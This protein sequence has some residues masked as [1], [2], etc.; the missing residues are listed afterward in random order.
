MP[1][2]QFD[3]DVAVIGA[4]AAGLSA[5]TALHS[6]HL[7]FVV[8]EASHRIGG[9]AYTEMLEPGVPFDLGAHWIHSADINPFLSLANDLGVRCIEEVEEFPWARVFEDGDWLPKSAADDLYDFYELQLAKVAEFAATGEDKSIY[10]VMDRDDRWTPYFDLFFAQDFVHDADQVSAADAAAFHWLGND[11]AVADGFGMLLAR[12]GADVPVSLNSAV[13]EVDWSGS[14]VRLATAKG[15]VSARKVIITVSTGVL[16]TNQILFKPKLPDAKLEAIDKLTMGHCTRV[17]LALDSPMLNDFPGEF[18]IKSG[19]AEPLHFRNR[20]FDRDYVEITTG[21][22]LAEWMEKS[23]ERATIDHIVKRLQ[24]LGG[25]GSRI[26]V[27]K[28]IV[29]AWT[30]DP[31]TKGAYSA[32]A[33]GFAHARQSYAES[34]DNKLFFAGEAAA[35]QYSTVHGAH[36]SGRDAAALAQAS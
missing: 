19:D 28:H 9:R 15:T 2:A 1:N 34:I 32:A 20:P 8:L 6:A 14:G 3:V 7:S 23:G 4:G 22:R 13:T 25:A 30:G 21:G 10:D 18:T 26:G 36:F 16:A 35:A 12:Y 27:R 11:W 33:P 24:E 29:T 31:W 17:C 5:A